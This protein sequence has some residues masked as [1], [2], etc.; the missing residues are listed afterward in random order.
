MSHVL[1]IQCKCLLQPTKLVKW[2]W[3]VRDCSLIKTGLT[4]SRDFHVL[5]DV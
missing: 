2:M 4:T 5:S 1:C 3:D